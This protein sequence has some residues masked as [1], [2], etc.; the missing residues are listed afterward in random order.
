[1]HLEQMLLN[2]IAQLRP[3]S[4][5]AAMKIKPII[6]FVLLLVSTSPALAWNKAGHML[7]AALAYQ[8][9]RQENPDTIVKIRT[10]LSS[11]PWFVSRW[12]AQLNA[13]QP[14]SAIN[15]FL[16]WRLGGQIVREAPASITVCFVELQ[17]NMV[18]SAW[19]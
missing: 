2:Q 10:E 16:C 8:I 11:H 1:M 4:W 6:L 5:V 18:T 19:T 9:L 13:V 7:S 12:Q 14:A 15:C 17:N 3:I